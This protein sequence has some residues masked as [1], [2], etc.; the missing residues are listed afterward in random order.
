M[1][2]ELQKSMYEGKRKGS[3]THEGRR[4]R[5]EEVRIHERRRREEECT[6][7]GRGERR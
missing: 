3:K 7:E 1:K 2:G 4:K 5:E 6:K